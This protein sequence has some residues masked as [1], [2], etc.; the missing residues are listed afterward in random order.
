MKFIAKAVCGLVFLGSQAPCYVTAEE[1]EQAN[2]RKL[3][4]VVRIKI[5]VVESLDIASTPETHF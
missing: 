5:L 3:D 4:V 2:L 1:A